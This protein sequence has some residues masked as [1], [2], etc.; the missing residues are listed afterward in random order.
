MT[1]SVPRHG[2]LAAAGR[3]A[4]RPFTGLPGGGNP[5]VFHE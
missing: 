5:I 1:M 3:F 2:A 4:V